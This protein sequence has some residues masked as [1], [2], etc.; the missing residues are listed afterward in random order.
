MQTKNVLFSTFDVFPSSKG[1]ATHIAQT[2]EGLQ[3]IFQKVFLVCSGFSDMP[4]YQ[5][6]GNITVHRCRVQ[7]RNFLKRSEHFGDFLS[8]LLDRI[9]EPI[10]YVHFR[11]IW[12][13][14]PVLEHP[15]FRDQPGETGT[16]KIFEVNGLP[17]VELPY[18]YPMLQK[19]PGFMSRIKAMED[20]CMETADG[21][22]T[23]S[24]VNRR[25][26]ES[27][28]A[29]RDKITV[30]PNTSSYNSNGKEKGNGNTKDM[31]ADGEM[32]LYVGTFSPWQ[33][34]PTLI[35]A[36]KLMAEREG[37]KLCILGSNRKHFRPIAKML[38]KLG[39]EDRVE[40]KTALGR[41]EVY[42]YYKR[43]SFT[44]A[45][46]TRC[47]RNELQGCSPLKIIESMSVGTP[48]IASRLAV[49]SEIVGHG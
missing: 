25:Y 13:G 42:N 7:D 22:I 45:P 17:S 3:T 14:I 9:A 27:R 23:V 39:L 33:G 34:L 32:I 16:R 19:N 46:L 5:E 47:S 21:I 15:R 1:A 12:S 24:R 41:E 49:C 18:Y 31:A 29:D 26:L 40:V 8:S 2:I 20:Y 37:L 44:V 38:R 11:D 36:F 43:A 28:G 4:G 10:H 35:R 48:V 6:E 30:T